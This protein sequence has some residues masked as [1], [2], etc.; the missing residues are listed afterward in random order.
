MKRIIAFLMV[1]MLMV[2]CLAACNSSKNN[3]N[4][5][6]TEAEQAASSQ[7]NSAAASSKEEATESQYEKAGSVSVGKT[8]SLWKNSTELTTSGDSK[9]LTPTITIFDK[10]Y[11]IGLTTL[12]QLVDEGWGYDTES[13]KKVNMDQK[14]EYKTGYSGKTLDNN[15]AEIQ[16]SIGNYASTFAT[17]VD[18][19]VTEIEMK[20]SPDGV[21]TKAGV[22]ICG[23]KIDLSKYATI[24]DLESALSSAAS[25][26]EKKENSSKS[27]SYHFLAQDGN[28][29]I[30]LS[31]A[32]DDS[33]KIKN[34][35]LDM[36]ISSDYS[37]EKKD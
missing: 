24:D 33:K 19:I 21:F 11:T 29:S 26:V 12:K 2:G 14:I 30:T 5:T 16:V 35:D 34:Y 28:G 27:Y 31:V 17:P 8:D 1:L 6:P 37:F 3:N 13:W 18:C 22:K 15:T 36:K 25:W 20:G 7:A 23:D 32:T 10:E 4:N 9:E